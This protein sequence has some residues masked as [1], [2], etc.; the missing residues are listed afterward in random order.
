MTKIA[1]SLAL[2]ALQVLESAIR[3]GEAVNPGALSAVNSGLSGLITQGLEPTSAQAEAVNAAIG[4]LLIFA[5]DKA[6][7]ELEDLAG[8]EPAET[9]GQPVEPLSEIEPVADA[10]QPAA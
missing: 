6:D 3:N 4:N 9:S 8:G 10:P 5:E 1:S 2:T 7:A